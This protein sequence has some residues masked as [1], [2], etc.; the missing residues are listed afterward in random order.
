[1]TISLSPD[2]TASSIT[3]CIVGLSTSGSV[4]FGCALVAGRKRVPSPA[5]GNAA[6]RTFIDSLFVPHPRGPTTFQ[7]HEGRNVGEGTRHGADGDGPDQERQGD[8]SQ[9]LDHV[10]GGEGRGHL[11]EL[12]DLHD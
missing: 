5:A 11:Q 3:Y 10:A 9:E 8:V 1:M 2:A 6:L 4:F 12:G 7:E